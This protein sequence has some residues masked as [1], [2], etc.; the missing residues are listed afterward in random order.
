MYSVAP[1]ISTIRNGL[2]VAYMLS[3]LF[4]LKRILHL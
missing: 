3:K 2:N 1:S 4:L